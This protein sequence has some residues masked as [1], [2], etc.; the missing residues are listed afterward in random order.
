MLTPPFC[1]DVQARLASVTN[2]EKK[3]D[4]DKYIKDLGTDLATQMLNF[5]LSWLAAATYLPEFY[6]DIIKFGQYTKKIQQFHEIYG[7][8]IRISPNEVHCNDVRFAD[9]IYPLGGR[10]RDKPLHQARDSGAVANIMPGCVYG[11]NELALTAHEVLEENSSNR[12]L[13]AS[14][15]GTELPF[16]VHGGY[17][18]IDDLADVHLKVLRLAPGPESI[19]NFGA[20]VDIDYTGTFGHVEKA[21]PKAVADGTLKRG[22]MP[23]LPISYDS[24]ETE[25]ALGIKFRPFEDAVVDTARQ[26]LE[27]LGKELA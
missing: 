23:T 15:T 12:F 7:P 3:D 9:E 11:R 10:K 25:K 21:F 1:R 19:S 24:S 5:S 18:H 4:I 27:K 2:A 13:M 6:Y 20:S 14:I 22:N 16:P 17:V 8:I 26:Y